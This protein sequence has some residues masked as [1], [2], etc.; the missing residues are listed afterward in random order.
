MAVCVFVL[1]MPCAGS[2]LLWTLGASAAALPLGQH[3]DAV[4]AVLFTPDGRAVVSAGAD[5]YL[6]SFELGGAERFVVHLGVSLRCVSVHVSLRVCAAGRGLAW[7]CS[8]WGG[9]GIS[10]GEGSID[11]WSR[12]DGTCWWAARTATCAWWTRPPAP[13]SKQSAPTPVRAA[14]L[15]MLAQQARLTHT[16]TSVH[17]AGAVACIEASADGALVVTGADD[18]SV[19]V[20]RVS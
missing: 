15:A 9:W 2:V 1:G 11:A 6:K 7:A 8:L 20:W 19:T 4:N 3:A 10:C 18:A 17:M 5:G 16:C 12:T 14:R 13:S